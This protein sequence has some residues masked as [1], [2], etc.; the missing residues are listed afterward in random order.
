MQLDVLTSALMAI[1]AF[2]PFIILAGLGIFPLT[3][4]ESMAFALPVLIAE[5]AAGILGFTMLSLGQ[6]IGSVWLSLMLAVVA[7]LCGMSQLEFIIQ[8]V[9]QAIRDG[10][11]GSFTRASGEELLGLQFITTARSGTPLSIAF[12]DLDNFKQIN[13][14]YGHEV[15]DQALI[16]ASSSLR[17]AIRSGDMLVRWGGEEFVVILPGATR[18]EARQ[19][20]DRL[21][22]GGL[23]QRPDGSRLTASVGVAER[24]QDQTDSSRQLVG[25]ADQRMYQAKMQGKNRMVFH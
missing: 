16:C 5:L 18:E 19:I 12:V 6:T 3:V 20:M 14:A 1:Y 11:T 8:L 4:L 2:L 10:L 24:M 21:L 15:G 17:T 22:A 9:R 25:L 23:G 13:D 7:T